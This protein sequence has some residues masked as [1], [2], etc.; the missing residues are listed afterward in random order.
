[1]RNPEWNQKRTFKRG[2]VFFVDLPAEPPVEPDP[3]RIL[4]GSHRCVVLF[5]SDFPRKTVTILPIT[6]L[7]NQEGEKKETTRTDLILSA[8]DYAA[9]DNTYRGTIVK[10]SFIKT[11][12]IRSISR[13]LLERK[14]GELLPE[15]MISLDLLLIS[16]LQLQKTISQLIEYEVEKRLLSGA[17]RKDINMER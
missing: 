3:S 13:H 10:D 16:S 8:K 2:E 12:Q 9:A 6:S 4:R 11:E 17:Q 15:D 14:V 5:D 1:M 7:Y